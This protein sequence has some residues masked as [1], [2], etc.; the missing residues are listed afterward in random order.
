LFWDELTELERDILFYLPE[1]TQFP[2]L[3]ILQSIQRV[4]KVATRRRYN[5]ICTRFKLPT[6][7]RQQYLSITKQSTFL[8]LGIERKLPK[9]PKYSGYTKHYRD[10][11][12]LG[13][14][15]REFYLPEI[16]PLPLIDEEEFLHLLTV[17]DSHWV[18]SPE[19]DSNKNRN[20][21]NP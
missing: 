3:Q 4:G 1:V 16:D 14:G 5:Q 11:G 18:H 19:D 10:Q 12:S 7:T 9:G 2:Q 20:S 8:F 17:G 21:S 6:I 13:S 15:D